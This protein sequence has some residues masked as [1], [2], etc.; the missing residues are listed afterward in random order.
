LALDLELD[1]H[2][3]VRLDPRS[4]EL[5]GRYLYDEM[6]CGEWF[7]VMDELDIFTAD[8]ASLLKHAL[9]DFGIDLYCP[10]TSIGDA[11]PKEP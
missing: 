6:G 7:R 5:H 9:A 8:S 2:R 11:L 4:V 1:V 10:A 3:K